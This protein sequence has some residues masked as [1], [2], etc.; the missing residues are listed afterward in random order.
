[1][2][3]WLPILLLAGCTFQPIGL[4]PL[5]DQ[6]M[7]PM[8]LSQPP[9]DL[10]DLMMP[11]DLTLPAMPML[12]FNRGSAPATVDLTAEGTRDWTHYGLANANAVDRKAG[13]TPAI[14]A[15]ASVPLT[16]YTTYV[17]GFTWTNGTP[18][19]SATNTHTGVYVN[20]ASHGFTITIPAEKAMHTA[21]LYLHGA[22][23]TFAFTAVLSDGSAVPVTESLTFATSLDVHYTVVY[24]AASAGQTLQVTWTLTADTGGGSVDLMGV[25][26]Q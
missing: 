25:T 7:P 26:W 12:T 24:A 18:T 16:Q 15:S 8:D 22:A 17:P 19:A 4:T 23:G 10:P 21:H 2:A 3:R 5:D 20:G 14:M 13:V 1:V 9:L 11:P 6:G